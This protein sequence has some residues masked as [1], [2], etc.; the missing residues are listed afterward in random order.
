MSSRWAIRS[1]VL[2]MYESVAVPAVHSG[3]LRISL[4]ATWNFAMARGVLQQLHRVLVNCAA[5][6]SIGLRLFGGT[7]LRLLQCL[8]VHIMGI[9]G[10]NGR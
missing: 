5:D 2:E 9:D 8:K 7:A 6:T 1:E 3:K 10:H 4:Q